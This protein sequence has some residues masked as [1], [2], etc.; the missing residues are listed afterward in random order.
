MKVTYKLP[1]LKGEER[2]EV[3]GSSFLEGKFYP[4]KTTG[5]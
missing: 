1:V 3:T 2:L 5:V 4:L